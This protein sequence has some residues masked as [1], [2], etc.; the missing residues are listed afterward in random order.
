MRRRPD[1]AGRP[2]VVRGDGEARLA[3]HVR[4]AQQVTAQRVSP[5]AYVDSLAAAR[6]VRAD[7]APDMQTF[8]SDNGRCSASA[9]QRRLPWLAPTSWRPHDSSWTGGAPLERAAVVSW[10]FARIGVRPPARPA[11]AE[12]PAPGVLQHKLMV[13]RADDPL[14]READSVARRVVEMPGPPVAQT[15]RVRGVAGGGEV[16]AGAPPL[17]YEALASP[18]RGLDPAT[19][20]FMESRFG[21]DFGRVRV[22]TD[23]K[24][25]ESARAVHALAF[26]VGHDL[27]FGE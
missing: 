23:A 6:Y 25:A 14:E 10:N 24:A 11:P 5:H 20:A 4:G 16:E 12:R 17:V 1:G 8:A 27:V 19:R 26:T 7:T 15:P 13:G 21:H 2:R 18:E 9:E 3:P 22:H